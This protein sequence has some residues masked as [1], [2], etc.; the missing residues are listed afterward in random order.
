MD[1][2][3]QSIPP[4]TNTK[5]AG[6]LAHVT[7]EMYKKNFELVERN[8]TL[9]LLRKIHEII[10]SSVTDIR[11]IAQSVAD[12]V[13]VEAEFKG[14]VI[15]L[16]DPKNN[17]LQRLAVSQTEP[18]AKVEVVLGRSFYP[19]KLL[20]SEDENLVIKSIKE[21]KTQISHNLLDILKPYVFPNEV[22]RMQET[23]H[24]ASSLIYPFIVR[25]QVIG[26][27][28]ICL[29]ESETELF[30]YQQDLIERL[31]G[32]IGIAL[33]NAVLYQELQLANEA[34]Q[35]L[36][37]LKDEFVSLASHELRT[38]M[39]AIKS[40]LWM[41]LAGKGGALPEKLQ[42]YLDRAY[43]STDRLIKLVNDML[44]VS[45]IESGRIVL[46]IKPV[47]L[48]TLISDTITEILPQAQELGVNVLFTPQSTL[49]DVAADSDKI[50]EVIINL[51]GNS[52][53]F[54]PRG[55]SVTVSREQANGMALVKVKDTGNGISKVD[56]DKLFQKFSMV[57]TNYLQKQNSQGT[58]LGL[59]ISKSLIELH[60]GK[61]SVESEGEGRGTTF[62]FTLPFQK[63]VA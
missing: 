25:D 12:V 57:G 3:A 2:S 23:L 56:M 8:K 42:F 24:I 33:D 49:P 40:Y 53:K 17:H 39:T 27:M 43:K 30:R 48:D 32:V 52:L 5:L 45:R 59:Y 38:P 63:A 6:E 21:K 9:L 4:P 34:L 14:V 35:Q 61:I 62:S 41:A 51:V 58:G 15:L 7:Q 55:G 37:K 19:E 36:D 50:K 10:L 54:T 60:G 16:L 46:A 1:D 13:A 20:L 22:S 47:K 18:I 11:Q 26:A 28:I 44:N 29:S 31:A